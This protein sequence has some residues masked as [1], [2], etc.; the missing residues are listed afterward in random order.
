M[1]A[2]PP[3]S[4]KS[5]TFQAA[6]RLTLV[7]VVGRLVEPAASAGPLTFDAT[8]QAMSK[9]RTPT[10]S[11]SPTQVEAVPPRVSIERREWIVFA[12]ICLLGLGLRG[13]RFDRLSIEHFDE[14]VYAANVYSILDNNCYPQR[15]L[16]APPLFPMLCEFA[17]GIGGT[18]DAAI[19][20]NLFFGAL[21]V[22]LVWIV[23]RDTFGPDAAVVSA[24]LCA[25]SDYH[26]FFSRSALTDVSLCFWLLLAVWLAGRGMRSGNGLTLGGAG[27]AAALA[28][29]TKYN[30]W[31]AVAIPLGGWG[32]LAIVSLMKS[33]V[34]VKARVAAIDRAGFFHWVVFAGVAALLWSPV[35]Y[36][37][38]TVGGD[39]KSVV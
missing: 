8:L 26:I 3:T 18:P 1:V 10:P 30:G 37:L 9:P 32:L 19:W 4:E 17:I 36:D 28:W 6:W 31:L 25:T 2:D 16:Y 5:A 7:A 12:V 11:L 14:G 29:W 15:H 33:S 39:R 20:I 27:I 22:P 13:W 35:V 23:V 24:V 21:M 34:P 38:Q